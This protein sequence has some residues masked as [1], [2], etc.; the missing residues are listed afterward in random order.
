MLDLYGPDVH[1][2]GTFARI[3]CWPG[4]WRNGACGSSSSIIRTGTITATCRDGMP[5]LVPRDRS[6]DRR[7]R[8]GPRSSAACSTTRW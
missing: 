2:P 1:K 4:G 5:Q 6:A 7:P 3:A 8:Q